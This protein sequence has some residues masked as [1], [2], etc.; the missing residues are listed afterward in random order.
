M[1]KYRV[2]IFPL[3][4]FFIP[5]LLYVKTLAPTYIPIDAAEFTLCVHYWGVCHPPG[6]PLYILV[7]KIFTSIFPFGSLIYK[8]NFI[9][10]LFGG[11]TILL[12]YLSMIKL[13]VRRETAFLLSI[14]FAVSSI[15]WEF[16]LS[17]DVFSFSAFLIALSLFLVF[18]K[19][20]H[21][22]FLALGLSSSHFYLSAVMAPVFVWYLWH[23]KEENRYSLKDFKVIGQNFIIPVILFFLGFFPQVVMYLRMQNNPVIDW[24][25]AHGFV[26]FVYFVQRREFGSIFLIANPVLTFTLIKF[27]KH[28]GTYFLSLLVDFGVIL[29]ILTLVSLGFW[30]FLK[31]QSVTFLVICFGIMTFIQLFLLSTIEPGGADNPFQLNK[32]YLTTFVIFVILA[33]MSFDFLVK[34]FFG[35]DLTLIVLVMSLLILI[36][37]LV[38]YKTHDY[39]KNRFTENLVLDGLSML[40]KGSL[41]ITVDHPFYFGGLYEQKINSKFSDL[42]LLYFPNEKNRDSENYH[43]EVFRRSEDSKFIK[44]VKQGKKLGAAEEY[45][46][47]AI[48]KNLDKPIYILQGSFEENFFQYLKPYIE[49]YGLFW[50]VKPDL[51]VVYDKN[52]T[53]AAFGNLKNKGI[54]KSDFVL[55]QQASEA[56]TYA[57]SFHSSGVLL[58]SNGD[59]DV[60]R[61]MFEK[62]LAIDDTVMSVR[63]ELDLLGKIKILQADKDKI[64]SEKNDSK[65]SEL[66]NGYFSIGD[67]KD[68]AEIFEEAIKIW[69]NNAQNFNNAASSYAYLGQK[70]KAAIY[71]K[72]AL[73]LNP[74]MDL[75]KQ[76][77]QNL[78]LVNSEN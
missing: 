27:F 52:R 51:N 71:Y 49:P 17:A 65:L 47:S 41:V 54:K 69:P 73:D 11:G 10:A 19:R 40:P 57:I 32:F 20:K 42:T 78:Q 63:N 76:G 43:P 60:A 24:G 4:V 61:E 67:Y 56:L 70:D 68:A 36:F 3:A 6:F 13:G 21:L 33:G 48:S 22:A 8:V 39:S 29:P 75:A 16:S 35:E 50:K 12:V 31:E 77:L 55:R 38:N 5:L 59:S 2:I 66:G 7:G 18:A 28:I 23:E 62:S 9:S 34:R 1:K 14:F 72:K 53:I 30:K 44:K 74:K 45:I 15:F 25:H 26:E 37:T 46:L 58:G 64:I